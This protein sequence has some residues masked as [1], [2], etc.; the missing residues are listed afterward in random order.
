VNRPV[1]TGNA[2]PTTT[3]YVGPNRIVASGCQPTPRIQARKNGWSRYGEPVVTIPTATAPQ[4]G[5]R[6]NANGSRP[7]AT[8]AN[9]GNTAVRTPT[10][11][12]V[13]RK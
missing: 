12:P 7:N 6:T 5:N 2:T 13:A 1:S 9:I 3:K 10:T 11:P 8:A 4:R